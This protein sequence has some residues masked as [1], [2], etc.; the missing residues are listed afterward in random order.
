MR[1]RHV[2]E[3]QENLLGAMNGFRGTVKVDVSLRAKSRMVCV[4]GR[5]RKALEDHVVCAGLL[6]FVRDPG[7]RPVDFLKPQSGVGTV[8]IDFF[9]DPLRQIIAVVEP[10]G[11]HNSRGSPV[12]KNSLPLDVR[13]VSQRDS[14]RILEPESA[15]EKIWYSARGHPQP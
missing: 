1:N 10:I 13:D 4:T 8:A 2:A 6:K 15:E 3:I 14:V 5:E 9:A 11:G 12:R 7:V